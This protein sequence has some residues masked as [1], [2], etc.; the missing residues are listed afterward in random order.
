MFKH[1][2]RKNIIIIAAILVVVVITI[3]LLSSSKSNIVGKWVVSEYQVFGDTVHTNEI[4]ENMGENF[5]R[6]NQMSILFTP[7]GSAIIQMPSLSSD[8][9]SEEVYDYVVDGKF[10]FLSSNGKD[11]GALDYSNGKIVFTFDTNLFIVLKKG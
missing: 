8:N 9:L 11:V 1:I 2:S 3:V 7:N 4:S 6:Y 10:I 5:S